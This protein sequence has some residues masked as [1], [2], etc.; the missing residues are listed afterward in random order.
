MLQNTLVA[1]HPRVVSRYLELL[2]ALISQA[3]AIRLK[4]D[5]MDQD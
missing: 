3:I 5:A 2:A 1:G 4:G